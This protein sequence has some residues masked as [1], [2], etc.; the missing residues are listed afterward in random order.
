MS[1]TVTKTRTRTK[2]KRISDVSAKPHTRA[3]RRKNELK[4]RIK[5]LNNTSNIR[6]LPVT[7]SPLSLPSPFKHLPKPEKREQSRATSKSTIPSKRGVRG[8][9]ASFGS[10]PSSSGPS[11]SGSDVKHTSTE[12]SDHSRSSKD[13]GRR[14]PGPT[15][16]LEVV[17]RTQGGRAGK[18]S[19]VRREVTNT[20]KHKKRPKKLSLDNLQKTEKLHNQLNGIRAVRG[21][22]TSAQAR[23]SPGHEALPE[24]S[25]ML[26]EDYIPLPQEDF[27]LAS[28]P[29]TEAPLPPPRRRSEDHLSP[30]SL[31]QARLKQLSQTIREIDDELGAPPQPRD[32]HC[33]PL[34]R[35]HYD[36]P[37]TPFNSQEP[38]ASAPSGPSQ[39]TSP[40]T[41]H[42]PKRK[43]NVHIRLASLS[44]ERIIGLANQGYIIDILPSVAVRNLPLDTRTRVLI[45]RYISRPS[46]AT[47]TRFGPREA[48]HVNAESTFE[49]WCYISRLNMSDIGANGR[50]RSNNAAGFDGGKDEKHN[51]VLVPLTTEMANELRDGLY[52]GPKQEKVMMRRRSLGSKVA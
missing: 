21:S 23:N 4:L 7:R 17:H 44:H 20:S 42:Q 29:L 47:I 3:E 19:L 35:S 31:R 15:S 8:S 28:I 40:H 5:E 26:T 27:D 2:A 9:V 37:Q 36:V 12:T 16:E 48:R 39:P 50:R 25:N 14:V 52:N 18:S 1:N 10:G 32:H 33:P 13:S 46:G 11:G 24:L 43:P 51:V 34:V 22:P 49:Q 41:T 45:N 38:Q 30:K 6:T